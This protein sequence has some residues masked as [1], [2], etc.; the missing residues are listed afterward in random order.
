MEMNLKFLK[1]DSY[2]ELLSH[3]NNDKSNFVQ[4][5]VSGNYDKWFDDSKT[6]TIHGIVLP[7]YIPQKKSYL[8]DSKFAIE[9]YES[10]KSLTRFQAADKRMW[11]YL[12]MKIYR[13]ECYKFG[14][15]DLARSPTQNTIK[16]H[17]FYEGR[18]NSTA[19]RNLLS[20]LFWAVK[21]TVDE[22]LDDKYKFTK[23]LI[24]EN[25]SQLFQDIT[26]RGRLFDNK[27]LIYGILLFMEDK[28]S[29]E[30]KLITP[31]LL[32]H[33]YNFDI[34]QLSRFEIQDLIQT[35]YDDLK[36][37]GRNEIEKKGF[38]RFK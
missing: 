26:Q 18:G 14:S 31:I 17:F 34:S 35:F 2:N 28:T 25:N 4:N 5:L 15:Y 12:T 37:I 10:L 32:N 33:L 36:K 7:K 9:F 29:D 1:T 19:S 11:G 20:K 27:E 16:Q 13:S 8:S 30:S 24:K 6:Y 21:Q 22:D 3:L 38:F 23:L